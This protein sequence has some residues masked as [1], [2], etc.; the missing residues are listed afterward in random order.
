V[1]LQA[2]GGRF[3]T[4]LDVIGGLLS[5]KELDVELMGLKIPYDL[6]AWDLSRPAALHCGIDLLLIPTTLPQKI[7]KRII[8]EQA[9]SMR[10]VWGHVSSIRRRKLSPII[11]QVIEMSPLENRFR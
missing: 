8:L 9:L 7:P 10:M 6:G 2:L 4:T 1:V 3:A 5:S 11:D